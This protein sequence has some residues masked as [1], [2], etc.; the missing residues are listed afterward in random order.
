MRTSLFYVKKLRRLSTPAEFIR[1]FVE[2]CVV[3]AIFPGLLKH[4]FALLKRSIKLISLDWVSGLNS[5]TWP[6]SST[7]VTSRRPPTL[8]SGFLEIISTPYTMRYQRKGRT[9]PPKAVSSCFPRRLPHIG[10][11]SS[12]LYRDSWLTETQNWSII[13]RICPE[14]ICINS[15]SLTV[16][17]PSIL[18]PKVRRRRSW[19]FYFLSKIKRLLTYLEQCW[20]TSRGSVLLIILWGVW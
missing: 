17:L 20:A 8:R 9:S 5:V 11:R 7:N 2:T 15:S 16:L 10:T 14:F 18:S 19:K 13:Y 6:T 4:D 1:K 12:R 3:P